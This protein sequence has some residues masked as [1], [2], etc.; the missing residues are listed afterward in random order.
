MLAQLFRR[1]AVLA[2]VLVP[3][4]VRADEPIQVFFGPKAARDKTSVYSN[5]LRFLDSARTSLHG[6]IHEIDMI[7]VAEKLAERS[8][9]GVDVQVIVEEQWYGNPKNKAARL[10]LERNKDKIIPH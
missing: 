1:L 7:S 3:P 5:L 4:T 6:S 8:R 10:V 2:V 9:Q